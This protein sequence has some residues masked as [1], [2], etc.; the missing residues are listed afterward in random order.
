[1][2]IFSRK[3]QRTSTQDGTPHL[4]P[5]PAAPSPPPPPPATTHPPPSATGPRVSAFETWPWRESLPAGRV[6]VALD[7]KRGEVCLL[8]PGTLEPLRYLEEDQEERL[9]VVRIPVAGTGYRFRDASSSEFQP[10]SPVKLIPEPKNK[11]DRHAIQVRSATSRKVAGYVPAP[12]AGSR[13][14]QHAVHGLLS[15]GPVEAMVLE[16]E[17]ERGANNRWVSMRVAATRGSFV[18]VERPWDGPELKEFKAA[19]HKVESTRWPDERQRLRREVNVARGP[20]ERHFALQNLAQAAYRLREVHAEALE[21]AEAACREQILLAD[22]AG[23]ALRQEFGSKPSHHGYKQL[24]II[25]EKQ[26]R[27][28]E[29]MELVERA[30]AQGWDGDWDKR[31]ERMAKKV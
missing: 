4:P 2:G 29:A 11:H 17:V 30:K 3:K 9:G 21:D 23:P 28:H 31:A 24:A 18:F 26:K 10:G 8:D 19:A 22:V 16:A 25:L 7:P 20:V 14:V 5:P 27:F 1:M 13:N 6:P 15:Q 12:K